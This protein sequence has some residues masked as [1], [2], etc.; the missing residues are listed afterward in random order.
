MILTMMATQFSNCRTMVESL[1]C[2]KTGTVEGCM[3]CALTPE[4]KAILQKPVMVPRHPV[5]HR[6]HTVS[7][8]HSG[9]PSNLAAH[10]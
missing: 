1:G 8:S 7:L 4:H 10:T 5:C 2:N 3:A 6:S 9:S